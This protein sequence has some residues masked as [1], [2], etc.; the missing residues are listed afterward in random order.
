MKMHKHDTEDHSHNNDANNNDTSRKED[1]PLRVALADKPSV[2]VVSSL[3]NPLLT[4]SLNS[5]PVAS[6]PLNISANGSIDL[7][8]HVLGAVNFALFVT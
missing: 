3:A 2:I 8:S 7:T 5:P 1:S 6:G 4:A